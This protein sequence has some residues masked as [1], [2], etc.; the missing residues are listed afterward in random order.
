MY[1]GRSWNWSQLWGRVT[2]WFQTGSRTAAKEAQQKCRK[3]DDV[4]DNTETMKEYK[5]NI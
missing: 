2:Q 3:Q 5:V 4:G 1:Q